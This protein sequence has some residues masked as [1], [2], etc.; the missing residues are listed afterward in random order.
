MNPRDI[1][2]IVNIYGI[3]E[4]MRNDDKEIIKNNKHIKC[5]EL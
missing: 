1:N 2:L 4:G 5:F 3:H